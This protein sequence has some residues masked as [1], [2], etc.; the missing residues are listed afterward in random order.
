MKK[1]SFLFTVLIVLLLTACN[2]K[3]KETT[4]V[5]PADSVQEQATGDSEGLEVLAATSCTFN[6]TGGSWDITNGGNP[7]PSKITFDVVKTAEDTAP[8]I[9]IKYN[10]TEVQCI[11]AGQKRNWRVWKNI[12]QNKWYFKDMASTATLTPCSGPRYCLNFTGHETDF[13]LK[14]DNSSDSPAQVIFIGT[15]DYR[16][17]SS[18]ALNDHVFNIHNASESMSK[19]IHVVMQKIPRTSDYAFTVLHYS[20]SPASLPEC[21]G[22]IAAPT[23]A[24][25]K[26]H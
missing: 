15:D 19:S 23:D 2:N 25:Y 14:I 20:N 3:P 11:P 24:C 6:S 7:D 16:N 18:T 8:F 10:G 13:K 12:G 21:G 22:N 5:N 9:K 1:F 17:G 26:A 4:E